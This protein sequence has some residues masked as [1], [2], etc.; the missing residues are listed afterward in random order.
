MAEDFVIN[1]DFAVL[2]REDGSPRM[3]LAWGDRVRVLDRTATKVEVEV[4]DFKEQMSRSP[5]GPTDALM[6]ADRRCGRRST[7]NS[8]G[9]RCD[10]TGCYVC[11]LWVLEVLDPLAPGATATHK[12]KI[13]PCGGHNI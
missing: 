2:R 10:C 11:L 4:T 13:P 8:G 7:I 1:V 5:N 3:L 6:A 9:S 12:N